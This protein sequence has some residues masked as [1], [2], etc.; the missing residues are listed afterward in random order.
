MRVALTGAERLATYGVSANGV[1]AVRV[2]AKRIPVVPIRRRWAL[3]VRRQVT[4]RRCIS[5]HGV[6]PAARRPK[7][8]PTRTTVVP[9]I[10]MMC[11]WIRPQVPRVNVAPSATLVGRRRRPRPRR[12]GVSRVHSIKRRRRRPPKRRRRASSQ[13]P[14]V[15]PSHHIAR[16]VAEATKIVRRSWWK[17]G[18]LVAHRRG[19]AVAVAGRK[20]V[21]SWHRWAISL[22]IAW[23]RW[24]R[25]TPSH[26]IPP[27]GRSAPQHG[28]VPRPSR[29]G[30]PHGP[31]VRPS[32]CVAARGIALRRQVSRVHASGRKAGRRGQSR[33]RRMTAERA[34]RAARP[35]SVGP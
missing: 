13:L 25:P 15:A 26:W 32:S 9:A 17:P 35:H 21:P 8:V 27:R 23:R 34:R 14:R 4:K 33:R 24:R 19:A 18:R 6:V 22:C 29:W 20:P 11:G 2:P 12:H 10:S 28:G 31:R 1:P 16:S 5:A 30:A 7:R 3:A